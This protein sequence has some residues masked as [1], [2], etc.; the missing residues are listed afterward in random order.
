MGSAANGVL[1]VLP[2]AVVVKVCGVVKDG[3]ARGAIAAGANLI[4]VIFAKS[5]RQA[6]LAQ[7]QAVVHVVRQFGERT[8]TI[9]VPVTVSEKT[10]DLPQRC[11][12]LR[13]ASRRTPLVVGVFMA[14]PVE[15]VV[16][17]AQ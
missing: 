16:A 5:K 12:A 3:D 13:G 1:P 4:G 2:G 17:S 11:H 9:P 8:G 14:Q 7:A 6:S 10:L 15:D